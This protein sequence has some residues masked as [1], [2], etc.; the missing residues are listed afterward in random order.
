MLVPMNRDRANAGTKREGGASVAQVVEV[1]QRLDPDGFLDGL[2]V[3]A[4]EVAE[5]EVA[6]ARVREE[7]QAVLPRLEFVERLDRDRL[8]RNRAPVQPR[9][10]VLDAPVRIRPRMWTT[11]AAG[12]MS[13][14][15]SANSSEGRSP[16]AAANTTIGPR[17]GPSRSASDRI[18]CQDSN[19]RCSRQRRPGFGTRL[20]GIVIDQLPRNRPIQHL[21]RAWV[22]SKRLP[23]RNGEPPRAD[24][25]WRELNKAHLTQRGGRL[26]EQPAELRHRD[27]L[28]RMR[29]QVL[30]DPLVERQRR[31]TAAGQEP[32]KPALKCP[33]RL[34]PGAEPAYLQSR[35]TAPGDPI[36]VRPQRLTVPASR[37]QLEHLALLNHHVTSWID[38]EIQESQPRRDDDHPSS[39]RWLFGNSSKSTLGQASNACQQ[40]LTEMLTPNREREGRSPRR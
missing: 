9:L 12:S 29:A 18:C 20:A 3:A 32:G 39:E 28:S 14:C 35:R 5:V 30:L 8:Q 13:P 19:G 33:P 25:L 24:L 17:V 36:A 21:R 31:R 40:C 23:F 22:A 38:C 2:P 1:A 27:A 4:V 10:G 37:L 34:S 26:P 7:Q 15:S 11:P 6:A 16:V